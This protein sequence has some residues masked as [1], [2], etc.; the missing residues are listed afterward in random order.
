MAR[1]FDQVLAEVTA[2]SD[3]QRQTVLK[4]IAALPTQQAADESALEAQKNQAFD[5]IT[6]G[7]RR[8]GL[9][10]SGIPLGEQAKYTATEY[11]PALANLK[12]GYGQRR[13]TL[14]SALADVG[15]SDYM[16]AQDIY[17]R[18]RAFEEQQRQF[19]LQQRAAA[20]A[21]AWQKKIFDQNNENVKPDTYANV[22]KQGAT[23]A[24]KALLNTG[25]RNLIN[26]TIASITD[27]A[28]RGNTYDRFK[29][30]LLDLYRNNSSY[31]G[32]LQSLSSP[33]AGK[34][35][36]LSNASPFSDPLLNV[37][38]RPR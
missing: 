16:T 29:L 37:L 23:N 25:N 19:D 17:G 24:I 31:G 21:N 35:P 2:R 30:E 34:L 32:L 8:K 20:D 1:S 13:G 9:G 38:A 11:A 14:E 33:T 28:N 18:D 27:S 7:A 15:R 5:D 36:T 6:L 4:Q 3:P 10:F 12:S 22:D 26:K